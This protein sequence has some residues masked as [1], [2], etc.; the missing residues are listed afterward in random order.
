MPSTRKNR[1]LLRMKPSTMRRT[2]TRTITNSSVGS[3]A[4]KIMRSDTL[5]LS[6]EVR[7]KQTNLLALSS[8]Y[9][10]ISSNLATVD[11]LM[12]S[13]SRRSNNDIKKKSLASTVGFKTR[14]IR[15]RRLLGTQSLTI[16]EVPSPL[17]LNTFKIL[18]HPL[19]KCCKRVMP[20]V[21]EIMRQG[22]KHYL[23]RKPQ[24]H[25]TESLPMKKH[26]GPELSR[27]MPLKA[28]PVRTLLRSRNSTT[29]HGVRIQ[30]HK[31]MFLLPVQ[32]LSIRLRLNSLHLLT[33]LANLPGYSQRI[34][35]L[36]IAQI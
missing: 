30:N 23:A 4:E 24:S 2:R 33:S 26:S 22:A 31:K 6:M 28:T 29:S 18:R 27:T 10:L 7:H 19:P 25:R 20:A 21:V 11:L 17:M 12:I 34:P 14:P 16:Q 36:Y 1:S 32:L 5:R 13:L 8:I 15:H 35:P 3:K 9:T